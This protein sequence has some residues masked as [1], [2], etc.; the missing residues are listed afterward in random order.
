MPSQAKHSKATLS[1]R[2]RRRA[3]KTDKPQLNTLF[4]GEKVQSFNK[5]KDIDKE[6]KW[7][8]E[9]E[10]HSSMESVISSVCSPSKFDVEDEASNSML[11]YISHRSSNSSSGRVSRMSSRS[12]SSA[13][14]PSCS[15]HQVGPKKEQRRRISIQNEDVPHIRNKNTPPKP[16][17]SFPTSPAIQFEQQT[18]LEKDEAD[19]NTASLNRER[20]KT[21]TKLEKIAKKVTSQVSL[22]NKIKQ[23]KNP[24]GKNQKHVSKY[25][26][27][28]TLI[29]ES[30]ISSCENVNSSK[31]D[32]SEYEDISSDTSFPFDNGKFNSTDHAIKMPKRKAPKSALKKERLINSQ[33]N[34]MVH[35]KKLLG[36]KQKHV[37]IPGAGNAKKLLTPKKLKNSSI[38]KRLQKTPLITP[39]A[40]RIKRKLKRNKTVTTSTEKSR[41]DTNSSKANATSTVTSHCSDNLNELETG[42]LIETTAST[43]NTANVNTTANQPKKK[44]TP[45]PPSPSFVAAVFAAKIAKSEKIKKKCVDAKT[46]K[47][48]SLKRTTDLKSFPGRP[49]NPGED[50][51]T[52]CL[53]KIKNRISPKKQITNR[54]QKIEKVSHEK[55]ADVTSK[56]K[57][58]GKKSKNVLDSFKNKSDSNRRS[59]YETE[60]EPPFLSQKEFSQK[61]SKVSSIDDEE[62]FKRPNKPVSR[63]KG[64]A[65]KS[66]KANK[67]NQEKVNLST[68]AKGALASVTNCKTPKAS[69]RKVLRSSQR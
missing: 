5:V 22:K 1:K 3:K 65:P 13:S 30:K 32:D 67:S 21:T 24:L 56:G 26:C 48:N 42:T 66:S 38:V 54:P 45:N 4:P 43:S 28:K 36:I 11:S 7:E 52:K 57:G 16:L 39:I 18:S 58:I 19:S 51:V 31:I 62:I 63:R 12:I 64:K 46:T 10:F 49:K 35:S 41:D 9:K 61:R 69:E 17:K 14:L 37:S 40:S 34:N 59:E 53:R 23:K 60:C 25:E 6:Q 44:D 27:A 8:E 15:Q 2:P 29:S 68:N 47:S 55:S 33:S 50:M 20:T